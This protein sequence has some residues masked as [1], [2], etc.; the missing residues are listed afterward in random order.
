MSLKKASPLCWIMLL[1]LAPAVEAQ[2]ALK[3]KFE[4]GTSYKARET[5]KVAQSLKLAGQDLATKAE[6]TVVNQVTYGKRDEKGNLPIAGKIES[7]VADLSL[8]G[9]IKLH[10]DSAKPDEKAENPNLEVVLDI[11]RK[12]TGLTVTHTLSPELKVL[13]VEGIQEGTQLN[14]DELKE[15]YQQNIDFFPSEPVKPG[16]TW[17]RTV[18]QGLGQG[19]VLTYQRKYEY[20]GQAPQFPT[21]KDSKQL[22]KITATDSSVEYSVKPGRGFPITVNKSDL[23]VDSSKHAYWF[24]RKAGRV[25]AEEGEVKIKGSLSLTLMGMN[26]DG[27]LDLSM[28]SREEEID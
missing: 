3:P 6:N 9:G 22:D 21:V 19:Q 13:S 8:P 11:F 14:P 20:Q 5:T 10:F 15:E 28:N 16:D 23:K 12:L 25:V 26:L 18:V 7:I 1:S 4:P 2:V 17:E 27:D 24:D